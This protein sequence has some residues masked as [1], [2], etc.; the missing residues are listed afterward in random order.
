MVG[1]EGIWILYVLVENTKECQLIE[2]QDS[3]DECY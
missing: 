2:L 3:V 1:S